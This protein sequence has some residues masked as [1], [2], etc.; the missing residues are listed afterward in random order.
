MKV[1]TRRPGPALAPFVASLGYFEGALAHHHERILPTGGPQ[2]LVNLHEDTL[3]ARPQSEPPLD[4]ASVERLSGA[5]LSGP[6]SRPS[7]VDTSDQRRTL[8]VAFRPGGS[9]PFFAAPPAATSDQL[10]ELGDLWGDGRDL[11]ERL[12]ASGAPADML[13][14]LEESLVAHAV[15][16]VRVDPA[17]GFALRELERGTGVRTV[18]ER[19]GFTTRRF[20]R[21]FSDHVGL[22]PKRY[23]RVRRFQRVLASIPH[24]R[25][26]DW[27]ELAVTNGYFDQPHLI[28]DFRALS[29][30]SPTAYRPRSPGERNH[31]PL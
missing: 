11:C 19:L 7:L 6:R 9:Y 15:R 5:G 13:R 18:A 8:W 10:V 2:L 28:H 20:S 1:V 30:L 25:P 31:V 3:A 14:V 22:T 21:Q 26:V 27:A 16:P 12:H 17:I 29:G 4:R 24:D 23:A